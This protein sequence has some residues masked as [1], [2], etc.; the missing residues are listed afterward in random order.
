MKKSKMNVNV[1]K[2][3]MDVKV[4]KGEMDPSTQVKKAKSGKGAATPEG[5]VRNI[6]S[7]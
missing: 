5:I 2:G 6:L 1:P 4:I 7:N 3:K